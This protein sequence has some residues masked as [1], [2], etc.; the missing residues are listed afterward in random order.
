MPTPHELLISEGRVFL[1]LSIPMQVEISGFVERL[2]MYERTYKGLLEDD[3]GAVV[4]G[5]LHMIESEI[6]LQLEV[7]DL[8]AQLLEGKIDEKE[9]GSRFNA[10]VES[11]NTRFLE[12]LKE[13]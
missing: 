1:A 12:G 10:A 8:E 7:L 11:A 5:Q 2:K 13:G 6:L 3:P 9:H 4:L